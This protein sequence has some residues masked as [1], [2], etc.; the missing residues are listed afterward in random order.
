MVL[1]S[2]DWRHRGLASLLVD[3]CVKRLRAL[4]VTPVLDATPAG[5]PVYRHLGFRPGFEFERWEGTLPADACG[6]RRS[7]PRRRL[8]RVPLRGADLGPRCDRLDQAAGGVGRRALLQDILG[9]SGTAACMTRDG[10]G[11]A[12]VRDGQRAAQF[13]PLVASGTGRRS[14]AARRRIAVA[15]RRAVSRRADALA[16]ARGG[17]RDAR[18]RAPASVRKDGARRRAVRLWRSPVRARRPRIRMTMR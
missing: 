18:L 11:F 4:H 8:Y 13:G 7:T 15:R 6:T 16:R 10:S 5:Q 9:R 1:V 14:R 12:I 3:A 17:A 2:P